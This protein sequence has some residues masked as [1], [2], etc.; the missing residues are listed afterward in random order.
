MALTWLLLAYAAG[1]GCAPY[2]EFSRPLAALPWLA[3][4]LW[5]ACR[6]RRGAILLL[7]LF[8]WALG[9][10]FFQLA[11]TPPRNPGHIRS[12]LSDQP[13]TVEGTLLTVSSRAGERTQIDL[14]A[15][16]VGAEGILAP[17][18]GKIRLFL[19]EAAPALHPGEAIRFRSRLRAP[20]AFGTPGESDYPRQLARQ[21]IFVVTSLDRVR[22]IV[23][24]G[25][26]LDHSSFSLIEGWR[27]ELARGIE[28]HLAPD[29]AA[30]VKALVI[31]DKGSVTPQQRELLARGGVSHL[32]AISGLHLGL[33]ALFLYGAA[34]TLYRRSEGLLL[35]A[36][37]KR[38]LPLLLLP[39]LLAYLLLTGN[40]LPTRRAF[41]MAMAGGVL[42]VGARRV[43]P[44]RLLA[45]VAFL[46]LLFEPLALL[47]P[48]FQLSFAGVLGI[49]LLLPRWQPRLAP[50]PGPLRWAA[51]LFLTTLAATLTT[52]P[53]V[54]LHFHLFA[55]AGLFTNLFAVPAIGFLA[56]PL[57]LAGGL[58][59][60]L[61]VDGATLLLQGSGAVT[62]AVLRGV[63]WVVDRPL[64]GGWKIYL[65]PLQAGG[66]ALLCAIPCMAG[67]AARAWLQR[68]L[69]LA[70]AVVL[71][72]WQP[73]APATLTVTALSVGQGDAF[74][75]ALADGRNYLID[76]G[77]LHS[78]TFD[79]G[80]RLLAPA[81]GHLGVRA[82]EAVILTHDQ[83]DHRQ[84]LPHILEQ[85]PVRAFWCSEDPNGLD[86][87]LA[88]A[89]RRR[90]VPISRM[91]AGW[92]ILEE[93]AETTMA[94]FVPAVETNNPN[95]RSLVF[96]LRQG[97]DGVLLT[98]DLE[99]PGV[100]DLLAAPLPGP[101]NLLKLPHHGSRKSSPELLL[102]RLRPQQTFV[103]VGAGNAFR[104]PH[105]EVLAEL[106][107]RAI[108]LYR[109]DQSGSLRFLSDGSGWRVQH[110]ERG[111][112]R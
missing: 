47:E 4:L 99:A 93:T 97:A 66:V 112:F 18:R 6:R 52:T 61:W 73:A 98:G 109:T 26:A 30:L 105:T 48:S 44:L 84:G 33:I 102:D 91:A 92:S 16:R 86:P 72:C 65:S 76:G 50:L 39:L 37:P 63:Q 74:V 100:I 22:E 28:E 13:L 1:L 106:Q 62:E 95:D 36:P 46:I 64:L 25:A 11:S 82:L 14:E 80:E 108:P 2:L 81:L 51:L 3:A 29:S 53:A 24:L 17:V 68:G 9:V 41:L 21:G 55:P 32:F 49:L 54:L 71:L 87:A 12:F 56:V 23:V 34:L 5:L 83:A 45:S 85:F 35:L 8:L 77:G 58:L 101:V 89:L 103:S 107:Q 70:T 40:A 90:Q 111:L 15:H 57:G 59:L 27:R 94:L 69:L 7:L 38:L 60:P 20:R 10:S 75:V 31:G 104:F 88:A 42:L 43:E 19:D 67:G 96:Y 79:V 110:W 78:R